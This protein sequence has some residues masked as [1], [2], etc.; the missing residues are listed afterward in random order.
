[1]ELR[2]ACY[3]RF[4][5]VHQAD[6]SSLVIHRQETGNDRIGV[7]IHYVITQTVE[8]KS[9]GLITCVHWPVENQQRDDFCTHSERRDKYTRK[10]GC[11]WRKMRRSSDVYWVGDVHVT[12]GT[13]KLHA[14]CVVWR[15][16]TIS[17]VRSGTNLIRYCPLR[18]MQRAVRSTRRLMF[19][20]LNAVTKE[21]TLLNG[22]N[23]MTDCTV[24]LTTSEFMSRHHAMRICTD[25]Q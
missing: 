19:Y 9:R 22:A 12:Y 20:L 23:N 6:Y 11:R 15:L 17:R 21:L 4:N 3:V 7:S 14:G 18:L 2:V 5:F 8:T 10:T 25:G 16:A 13:A 1:V 24:F